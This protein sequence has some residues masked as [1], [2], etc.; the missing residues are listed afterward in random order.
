M[1]NKEWLEVAKETFDMGVDAGDYVTCQMVID[2][3]FDKGF[4]SESLVLEQM[5]LDTPISKFAIQSPYEL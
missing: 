2:D 4:T 3:M 1:D 5:L